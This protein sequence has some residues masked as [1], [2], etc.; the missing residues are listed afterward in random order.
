M[1]GSNLIDSFLKQI[2][3]GNNRNL[4]TEPNESKSSIDI[5]LLKKQYQKLKQ[6]QQQAQQIVSGKLVNNI[7]N[8]YLTFDLLL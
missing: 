6:R 2:Q 4:L 1:N 8:I 5:S 3:G 7:S